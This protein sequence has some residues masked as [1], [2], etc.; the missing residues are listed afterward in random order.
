MYCFLFRHAGDFQDLMRDFEI[1]KRRVDTSSTMSL[2]IKIPATL[3]ETAL[4]HTN[5][6]F[7]E[8][9]ADNYHRDELSVVKDKLRIGAEVA[10]GLFQAVAEK[11]MPSI[12][13]CLDDV[14]KL[15]V[16]KPVSLI[17]LVGGFSESLYM[18]E[19]IKDR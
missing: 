3:Y 17:L 15:D 8:L 7:A 16:C 1:V 13:Q 19:T 5:K 9:V 18:Q 14:I 12:D 6:K 10:R 2:T 4:K 11:L